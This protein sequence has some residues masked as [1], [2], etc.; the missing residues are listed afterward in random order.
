M[1]TSGETF[2]ILLH[3]ETLSDVVL[4]TLGKSYL[5]VNLGQLTKSLLVKGNPQRTVEVLVVD[6][7]PSFVLLMDKIGDLVMH[8]ADLSYS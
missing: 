1:D 5:D 4:R 8:N 3:L 7:G 2:Y 6:V